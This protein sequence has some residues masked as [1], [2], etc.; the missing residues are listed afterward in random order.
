[1]DHSPQNHPDF[2]M[3]VVEASHDEIYVCDHRGTTIYCNKTFE[4]N[5]GLSRD[6]IMG[7]TAM[8]L[9][10][11]GFSDVTPIPQVIASKLPITMEQHTKA[12]K[13]LIITANPVIN[14]EGEIDFIVENCRDITELERIKVKLE[15]AEKETLRYKHEVELMNR[16]HRIH[17]KDLILGGPRIKP[18]IDIA[19]R[20]APTNANILILGESGTGKT[21]LARYIHSHSRRNQ[22]PFLTINC[23][24]ISASLLES[25]LFGYVSGAFTGAQSKGKIGLVEL[26][27]GGTLFLDEIG[28]LP[29]SVQSKFLELIQERSFT[30]VGGLKKKKVDVRILCATN[31]NLSEQ[32]QKKTFREDLYY[33]LN[34]IELGLPPL[35]ERVEDLP[36]MLALFVN[37]YSKEFN[38]KK[39]LAPEAVKLLSTYTWPGNIRELQNVVQNLILTTPGTVI[40]PENMPAF[41]SPSATTAMG[42]G[43][44]EARHAETPVSEAANATAVSLEPVSLDEALAELEG[45]LI[46][47][48]FQRLGSSYKVASALGLS[49]TRASRLIRKYC[50]TSC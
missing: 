12:G 16:V 22:G 37:Q 30:P 13:T 34:V 28:E 14:D 8:Y 42:L 23:S 21:S 38:M 11:N 29:L 5:Y 48:S 44:T 39:Q 40:F 36:K 9:Q 18:I 50:G 46:R 33:R 20:V 24:T 43:V 4:E 31:Q 32:V 45:H 3:R 6:Q 41:L 1:M 27:D 25:E 7:K 17:D 47:E 10:E 2:F 19:E 35:R 49:Q 15:S 26:A